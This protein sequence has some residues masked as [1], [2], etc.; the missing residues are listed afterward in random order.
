[1][2]EPWEPADTEERLAR[3][4]DGRPGRLRIEV[5]LREPRFAEPRGHA[6]PGPEFA[7]RRALGAV[8]YPA[9]KASLVALARPYL[10]DN[11]ELERRLEE[12]PERVF[13]GEMEVLELL[14]QGRSA[15]D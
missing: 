13:G 10:G 3:G 12:L 2:A 15:S 14:Q 4:A 7:L 1:M 6:N 5:G 11:P 8:A 9:P